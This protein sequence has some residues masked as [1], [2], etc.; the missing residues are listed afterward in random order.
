MSPQG[1]IDN[2]GD[3]ALRPRVG[4]LLDVT[5]PSAINQPTEPKRTTVGL[6][7]ITREQFD[8]RP[9]ATRPALLLIADPHPEQRHRASTRP[10]RHGSSLPVP[11]AQAETRLN[12][13]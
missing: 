1:L 12:G 5:V 11:S 6:L 9:A 4:Q 2:R 7:H 3:E 13:G 8:G 10:P